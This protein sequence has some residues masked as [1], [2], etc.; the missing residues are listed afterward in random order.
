MNNQS[1]IKERV[2]TFV[3]ALAPIYKEYTRT[4]E[5]KK[6]NTINYKLDKAYAE[7]V[8]STAVRP[9]INNLKAEITKYDRVII[10]KLKENIRI[11]NEK[12]VKS[13]EDLEMLPA[14][15]EKS[16]MEVAAAEDNLRIAEL[17]KSIATKLMNEFKIISSVLLA[18]NDEGHKIN[19]NQPNLNAIKRAR[20]NVFIMRGFLK[21]LGE[22]RIA[23]LTKD[24]IGNIKDYSAIVSEL[25]KELAITDMESKQTDVINQAKTF[26]HIM[27]NLTT[28]NSDLSER[29]LKYVK[30][31]TDKIDYNSNDIEALAKIG[32]DTYTAFKNISTTGSPEIEVTRSMGKTISTAEDIADRLDCLEKGEFKP[33]YSLVEVMEK[34]GCV[35]FFKSASMYS[36]KLLGSLGGESIEGYRRKKIDS[37]LIANNGVRTIMSLTDKGIIEDCKG[38]EDVQ[39]MCKSAILAFSVLSDTVI[40]NIKV[41][42]TYTIAI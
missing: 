2:S 22:E 35:A 16:I 25:I 7:K 10:P 42:D 33:L 32:L 29:A 3:G 5:Y 20:N 38:L 36:V 4:E 12:V 31:V 19:P 30:M 37:F 15:R 8:R 27:K 17:N 9:E 26:L 21:F 11:A 13:L 1:L 34:D 28:E 24:M 6:Y 41:L 14:D 18:N 39:F 23:E 40:D